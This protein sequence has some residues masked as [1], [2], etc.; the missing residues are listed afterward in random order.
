[1]AFARGNI[2]TQFVEYA[3]SLSKESIVDVKA[4]VR[5]APTP[6]ES[7]TQ[8][9][10]ELHMEEIHAVS[11]VEGEL[12]FQVEDA[13]R[14]VSGDGPRVLQDIRL[15]YRWID[16]RTPANQAIFRIQSGVCRF[17]REFLQDKDFV[18]IH[19]PK[20]LGGASEGGANCFR[21]D[22]FGQPACLAQSPQLYKQMAAA[23]GGFGRVFEIGPVFRAEN[24]LTHRHMCEF[25]GLDFE[26]TIDEHYYEVL[27]L[28]SELFIS[29]F[30]N[31]NARFASELATVAT[32]YP[33]EPLKYCRPTLRLT[34]YE[35]IQLLQDAGFD[36]DPDEDLSTEHEKALGKIVKEMYGTDFFMMD[37]YPLAIRPFYSMPCPDHPKLSNSFDIFIRGEEIVSGAQRIHDVNLLEERAKWWEIPLDSIAS[38]LDAFRHGAQPHG[39]GGIGM[40]RVVML[41]LGLKNIRS[42]S[43]FPRD[44]KRLTP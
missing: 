7:A 38:Y 2:H 8:K 20:L 11:L 16:L 42:A 43:M 35:G 22:Y 4:V 12:P 9:N 26:M 36:A 39:G 5:P 18:E 1:M 30:D 29:I 19:S 34:Y 21:L 6:I 17:F 28:F 44:P 24:S 3:S 27:D 14:G 33:F 37:K 10:V 15:D 40:E 41:F 13:A 25:T 23:C 32:Q 31:L